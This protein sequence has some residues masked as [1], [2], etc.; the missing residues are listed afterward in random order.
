MRKIREEIDWK[1][2]HFHLLSGK[3]GKN[4]I[5]GK[6]MEAELHGLQA[7]EERRGSNASQA[8]DCCL[9]TMDGS[10]LERTRRGLQVL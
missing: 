9:E 5:A 6:E 7:G 3:V 2:E 8:V 10:L 1:E 4:R